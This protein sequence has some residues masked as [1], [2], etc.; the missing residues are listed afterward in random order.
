M[1]F[2][3]VENIGIRDGWDA[4]DFFFVLAAA[5]AAGART[6]ST[7][8]AEAEEEPVKNEMARMNSPPK[9]Q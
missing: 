4:L 6:S 7:A 3:V 1:W 8:G 9:A 2:C 5:P